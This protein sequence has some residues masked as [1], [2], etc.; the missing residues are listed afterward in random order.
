VTV[1]AQNSAFSERCLA[2]PAHE[3]FTI[4]LKNMDPGVP[5]KLSIFTDASA[6]KALF[7]GDLVNG[8]GTSTYHVTALEPGT[9]FFWCDVHPAQ[10]TGTFVVK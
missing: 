10:M 7:V 4:E 2:A 9:Y 5:H 6:S 8:P 1:S 3:P